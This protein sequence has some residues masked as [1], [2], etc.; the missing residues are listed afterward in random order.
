MNQSKPT[1]EAVRRDLVARLYALAEAF[2]HCLEWGSGPVILGMGP[3]WNGE[4]GPYDEFSLSQFNVE[5][6]LRDLY[7]YAIFGEQ[8]QRFDPNKVEGEDEDLGQILAIYELTETR[9][10]RGYLADVTRRHDRQDQPRGG[11]KLILDLAQA[12]IRLDEGD[13]LGLEDLALLLGVD[14]R[15]IRNAMYAQG[16]VRLTASKDLHGRYLVSNEEARRW[17]DR[18][19]DFAQTTWVG[20]GSKSGVPAQLSAGEIVPFMVERLAR[21]YPDEVDFSERVQLLASGR[22]VAADQ[23]KPTPGSGFV[24]ASDSVGWPENRVAQIVA[25]GLDALNPEDCPTLARMMQ[26]DGRWFTDQVMRAKFP[27]AMQSLAPIPVPAS[28]TPSESPL[29]EAGDTLDVVLTEAGINNGYI[30]IEMRYASRLFPS[31]SFG[32]RA[33]D[34]R[35][36]PVDLVFDGR[37]EASDIRIKSKAFASPRK[38]FNGWFRSQQAA[39]GDTVR[40]KRTAER[41]YELS[42]MA[43]PK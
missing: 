18:R 37:T 25:G 34:D 12:R 9:V 42:F 35:G 30:D 2:N 11:L 33:A 8:V 21:Y 1:F 38:R 19:S 4:T 16:E 39:P 7:R 43:Q 22:E 20:K 15:S 17:L 24:K 14:E 29:S 13:A 41:R 31:D 3:D 6:T 5:R 36:Q 10:V 32:G 23:L 26:V 27:E 40:F 28:V